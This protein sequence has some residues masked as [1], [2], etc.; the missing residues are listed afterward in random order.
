[1]AIGMKK[2]TQFASLVIAHGKNKLLYFNSL[3]CNA[4]NNDNCV[5]CS[6]LN[7]REFDG[8]NKCIC[9]KGY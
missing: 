5:T 9:Q 1:M 8:T 3:T 6:S 2:I 7:F 4:G